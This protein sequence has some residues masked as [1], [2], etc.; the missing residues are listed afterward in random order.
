[1]R[2]RRGGSVVNIIT[3]ASHGGEPV[4]T[5]YSAS[6]GALAT[7]TRNVGYPLQPDRIRVNGLNIG[8]TATEGEHGVQTGTGQADGLARR[9]RREPAVRPAAAPRRHRADGHLPAQRRGARWSPARSSTSTRPCTGPTASTPPGRGGGGMRIWSPARRASSAR[10]SSH[11]FASATAPR[12]SRPATR[13]VDVTD[14]APCAQRR[15]RTRPT[16]SSTRRSGTR[17][18]A[19]G[20][21]AA[22][23]GRVRRGDAQRR[24]RRQRRRRPRRPRS[25]RT[26]SSTAPKARRPRTSRRTRSTPT[27][28][29]RRRRELVVTERAERGTVARIAGVQGVHRARAERP[30]QQ[31]AGFGYFVASLVDALRAGRAL[32][33]LGRPGPQRA[34]PRRSLA[35]DAGRADLARARA[36]GRP[37]S[38][39]CCGG[40]HTDRVDARPPRRRARSA[41]TRSCSTS[42]A[43]ARGRAA[44]GPRPARHAPRRDGDG[45][46]G[47][48]SSCPTSTPSSRACAPSSTRTRGPGDDHQ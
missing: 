30:A 38:L 7:L 46:A 35:T 37:G 36:R 3:M 8:W 33:G 24:R 27:A 21:T 45:R 31:D 43:P 10:T 25:R 29:S 14:A 12:C 17:S 9:G 16:R 34:A 18:P 15:R 32:H 1:M 4:L 44:A 2:A 6:K 42:G 47:S 39:H 20:A 13:E 23:V 41:S 11:V 40:E 28:S 5:A 26:G 19:C 22:R 48:G